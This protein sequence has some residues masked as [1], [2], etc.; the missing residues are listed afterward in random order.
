MELYSQLKQ[1]KVWHHSMLLCINCYVGVLKYSGY[2]G[3][4]FV[5]SLGKIM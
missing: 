2:A 1:L 4:N 5:S 3:L